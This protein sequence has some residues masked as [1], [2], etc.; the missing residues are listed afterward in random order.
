MYDIISLNQKLVSELKEIAKELQISK[1]KGVK[2]EDLIYQILDHQA[3]NPKKE[4][5]PRKPITKKKATSPKPKA[6]KEE[7]TVEAEKK[8]TVDAK[9]ITEDKKEAIKRKRSRIK[10]DDVI[11]TSN[12]TPKESTTPELFEFEKKKEEKKETTSEKK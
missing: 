9:K 8:E 4:S 6:K 11:A 1:V 7:K 2:K 3:L 12:P 5:N 10:N